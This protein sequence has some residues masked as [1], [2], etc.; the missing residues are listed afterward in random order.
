M[1]SFKNTIELVDE[2]AITPLELGT[3]SWRS[4]D[5]NSKPIVTKYGIDVEDP[6][7]DIGALQFGSS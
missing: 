4:S 2:V 3:S 7:D 5:T 1:A 6:P